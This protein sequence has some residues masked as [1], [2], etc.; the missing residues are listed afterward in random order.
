M[1]K[2][3]EQCG[4]DF[5][6]KHNKRKFCC[7]PC[8]WLNRRVPENKDIE[9]VLIQDE[10]YRQRMKKRNI[11]NHKKWR[12]KNREYLRQKSKEWR[13]KNPEKEKQAARKYYQKNK[14][15]INAYRR[16]WERKKR[17]EQKT[18]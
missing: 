13:E 10:D 15:K 12:A 9:G 3:C 2:Q 17:A 16:E 11:E 4:G 6:A 8:H 5:E 14:E 18:N 7:L 1:T